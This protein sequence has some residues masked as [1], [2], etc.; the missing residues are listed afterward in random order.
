M[1]EISAASAGVMA[2]HCGFTLVIFLL[3][4]LYLLVP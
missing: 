2:I 4:G 3:L 1:V